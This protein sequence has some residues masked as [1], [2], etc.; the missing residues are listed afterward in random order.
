[1]P[2]APGLRE[3]PRGTSLP[4]DVDSGPLILGLSTSASGVALGSA[5]LFGD[6]AMAAALAGL[7]EATGAPVEFGGK[8]RATSAVGCRWGMRS[9]PGRWRRMAG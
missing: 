1:M 2:G 7:A 6:R 3:H 4:G 8:R 9:S 5:V